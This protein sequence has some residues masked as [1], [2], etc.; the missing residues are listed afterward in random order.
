ME[1]FWQEV[2]QLFESFQ[3]HIL[4]GSSLVQLAVSGVIA[5]VSFLLSFPLRKL[6]VGSRLFGRYRLLQ[7]KRVRRLFFP[8]VWFFLQWITLVVAKTQQWDYFILSPIVSLLTAWLIIQ[9]MACMVKKTVTF[10]L[11]ATIAWLVAALDIMGILGP[12][13]AILGKLELHVGHL[14]L[15]LLAMIQGAFAILILVWG[16]ATLSHFL[17]R[18]IGENSHIDASAK[19]LLSKLT[20]ISLYLVAFLWGLAI[21]GVNLSALAFMGGAIGVGLGFGLQKVVSNFV[22]GLILLLDKSVKPGDVVALTGADGATYG[23]VNRLNARYVSVRTRSGKEHL[24]PNEE[25]VTQK[26]ENWSYSDKHVR[27]KIRVGVGYEADIFLVEKLLLQSAEGVARVLPDPKPGVRL[28][29]FANSSIDFELRVWIDDPE[30]GI[31]N[32]KSDIQKNIWRLF[33]EHHITFPFPQR[34]IHIKS[35]VAD[36]STLR[37]VS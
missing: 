6:F 1:E 17:E 14:E 28:I 30:K 3:S 8:F 21:M 37:P 11:I 33:K 25:F 32:T 16:A 4:Q 9:F 12:L 22:C 18:R 10:R 20:K 26:V 31:R 15:T 36:L 7:R 2:V 5:G 24:I 34:D 29:A 27:L 19:V 13:R 35:G 23:F